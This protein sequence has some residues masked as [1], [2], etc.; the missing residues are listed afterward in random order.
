MS[1]RARREAILDGCTL[2]RGETHVSL[3][4]AYQHARRARRHFLLFML[5]TNSPDNVSYCPP[6]GSSR[7]KTNYTLLS[8]CTS[9]TGR[10]QA[11][12]SCQEARC[13]RFPSSLKRWPVAPGFA[14]S[15]CAG[16]SCVLLG[17]WRGGGARREPGCWVGCSVLAFSQ[18]GAHATA[19]R[20]RSTQAFYC[21]DPSRRH[22]RD[23]FLR[24]RRLPPL[25]AL[26]C[27]LWGCRRQLIS[28]LVLRC[29]GSARIGPAPPKDPP[30]SRLS[31]RSINCS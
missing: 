24:R 15:D 21:K 1:A 26:R 8:S 9:A 11:H 6:G 14:R 5:L 13:R 20:F 29:E 30:A 2:R 7:Q 16:R 18:G 23:S 19:Q 28:S 3:T 12:R 4:G 22:R 27:D 10:S 25:P 17:R 31:Q